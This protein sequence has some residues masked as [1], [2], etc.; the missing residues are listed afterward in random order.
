[1][2]YIRVPLATFAANYD[3]ENGAC[4]VFVEYLQE[5]YTDSQSIILGGMFFQSFYAQYTQLGV[6]AVTVALY[7]NLNAL[8]NTYIGAIDYSEGETVFNVPIA[9]LQT[10]SLT[11]RNGLPTFAATLSGITDSSP[12][13]YLDFGADHSIV[14]TTDCQTTG[15]GQYTPGDCSAEPTLMNMGFSGDALPENARDVGTFSQARFGGYIVSGTQYTSE[16]CFGTYN[17]KFVN[18]YAANQVSADNWL[19]DYDGAYGILGMGPHS[20]IWEGFVDPDTRKA[21]YS[22]ELGRVSFYNNGKASNITFGDASS[23]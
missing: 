14:W 19:Y 9:H 17:C 10:D 11:E 4:V 6:N 7:V 2:N 15:I 12:Y 5:L 21:Y 13:F 18:V 22:I 3:G 16:L 20:Y 23:A 1:L 8:P